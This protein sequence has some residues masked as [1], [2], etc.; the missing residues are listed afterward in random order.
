MKHLICELNDENYTEPYFHV[1][2]TKKSAFI[3]SMKMLE[4]L[5]QN[6]DSKIEI[7]HRGDVLRVDWSSKD[8]FY[9]IENLPVDE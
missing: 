6:K 7:S 2:D 9:V 1:C 5:F 8:G 4:E 3:E